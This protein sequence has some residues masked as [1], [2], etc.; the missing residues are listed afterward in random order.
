ME[1]SNELQ[2]REALRSLN[3]ENSSESVS[4]QS[5][6]LISDDEETERVMLPQLS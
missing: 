5:L 4:E 6:K 1:R 3:E 2:G